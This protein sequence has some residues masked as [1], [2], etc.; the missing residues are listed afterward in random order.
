MNVFRCVYFKPL[1]N[2]LPA[3][4]DLVGG[5]RHLEIINVDDQ[6]Q[7][8]RRVRVARGPFRTQRLEA[9]AAHMRIAVLLPKGTTVSGY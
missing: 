4:L 7:V 2:K 8:K 3:F 1:A 6:E 9:D 5:P